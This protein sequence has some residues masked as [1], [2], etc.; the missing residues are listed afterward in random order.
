MNT[1]APEGL[2]TVWLIPHFHY[3]PVWWNTQSAYT[4]TWDQPQAADAAAARFAWPGHSA[5]SLVK[6]HLAKLRDDPQYHVVLAEVDYLKPYWDTYPEDRALIRRLIADGRLELVGGTYNEPNTNLTGIETTIRNAVHGVGF[7]RHVIGGVPATAWQLDV[8]GHDPQFAQVMSGAGLT[9]IAFAR[10]P[11]HQWGPMLTSWNIREH[12]KPFAPV[13]FPTEFEWVS[14]SGDGLLTHYMAAHYSAGFSLDAAQDPQ[15]AAAELHELF[16]VLRPAAAT[17]NVMVPL[18]SDFSPPMRWVTELRAAWDERYPQV[19]LRYGLP[20]DFF[21]AVRADLAARGVRPTPQTRDMNPI[22]TGKDVTAID[23]KQAH[24]LVETLLLDAEKWAT[25]AALHGAAYPAAAVD[26]AWRLLLFGAHH[27]AVTGTQSDQVYLDLLAGWREA[28]DLAAEV[29]RSARRHLA[30]HVD[31]RGEGTAVVVFNPLAHTRTDIVSLAVELG[32]AAGVTLTDDSGAPVPFLAETCAHASDGQPGRALLRWV[33]R[34]VPSL[35]YRTYRLLPGAAEPSASAWQPVEATSI[36]NDRYRLRADPARGGAL[37]EI[38]D[39]ASGRDILPRGRVGNELVCVA[40]H[41]DHPESGE[42]PWHLLP[43]A[44]AWRSADTAA[45]V[46]V[47]RCPIGERITATAEVDGCRYTQHTTVWHG[48]SRIDFATSIDGFA[49]TDRL[50]RVRIP[51][52]VPGG[53]PVSET[54]AAVIGRGYALLDADAAEHPRTLDNTAHRWFG[55]GA[56]LTVHLHDPRQRA[57]RSRAVSIAEIVV[58]DGDQGLPSTRRLAVGLARAGVTAT[59]TTAAGNRY[60]ALD[61]DSNLPDCRVAVGTPQRNGF[62]AELLDRAPARFGAELAAQLAAT[63]TARLWIP[64]EQ[65]IGEVWRPGADVRSTRDLPVLLIAGSDARAERRAVGDVLDDVADANLHV[66]QPLA[67]HRDEP[68]VDDY[69]VAL[70]NRG[71]PGF[72]VESDGTLNLSLTRACTGWPT[73]TAIDFPDRNAPGGRSFQHH[74]SRRFDYHLVSGPGGWRTAGFT[75]AGQSVNHPLAAAVVPATAGP[76][77]ATGSLLSVEPAENFV[78][79]AVKPRGEPLAT[80]ATTTAD[81]CDSLIVRG[82]EP[83]G[84][85][86]GV[87]IRLAGGITSAV[88]ADL[89]DRPGAPLEHDGR[90]VSFD[91]EGYG[92]RSLALAPARV[93]RGRTALVADTEPVRPVFTRYWLHNCGPAPMGNLP[94]TVTLRPD[95]DEPRRDGTTAVVRLRAQIACAG[96]DPGYDGNLLV[97]AP[98][99]W[100]A[101]PRSASVTVTAEGHLSVPVTVTIPDAAAPGRYAVAASISHQGQNL[102]D[103]LIVPVGRPAPE[104]L[105]RARS[106]DR[107]LTLAPGTRSRVRVRVAHTLRTPVHGHVQLITPHHIWPLTSSP[108]RGFSLAPGAASSVEF[109]VAVPA[110]TPPGEFWAQPKICAFG[111]ITYAEPVRIV[112]RP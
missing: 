46:T 76:L 90:Q 80:G 104:P 81:P 111:H 78:V 18:G 109:P 38:T 101:E 112:V 24:R 88:A 83:H 31:T 100:I 36:A 67:L 14:P 10:G 63:G 103:V 34:D 8:F 25:F 44:V 68:T 27:D 75:A 84:H 52:D 89:L 57:E 30:Q 40:E 43:H 79:T 42:G 108:I 13:Q 110:A 65:P 70:L 55:L 98:E 73:G 12:R 66:T 48:I 54:A 47:E 51:C 77:P 69:T 45:G 99:G 37:T 102:E 41:R 87:A 35:G 9:S 7:Q 72:A 97:S 5:F 4:Q 50:L 20:R 96:A 71:T 85:A 28:H 23:T 21:A 64:A 26:K 11:Y 94:V 74:T 1:A 29:D 32:E 93:E 60:G 15:T 22:Y 16:A 49:G 2:W 107:Q 59:V 56:A 3:D 82:Y 39:L 33:A 6:A 105:L 91:V 53:M 61:T 106:E 17:R 86:G 95:D 92:I 58:P 19:R 62:V